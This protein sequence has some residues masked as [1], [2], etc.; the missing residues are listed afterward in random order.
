MLA[1]SELLCI[2]QIEL[3][4]ACSAEQYTRP[5]PQACPDEEPRRG[6]QMMEEKNHHGRVGRK[7]ARGAL[8]GSANMPQTRSPICGGATK[9]AQVLSG[10]RSG[11]R[12]QRPPMPPT[13]MRM[14]V[15][16]E[17]NPRAL[18]NLLQMNQ[19]ESVEA[20]Q[21]PEKRRSI[22]GSATKA[23]QDLS[24]AAAAASSCRCEQRMLLGRD[25]NQARSSLHLCP[26]VQTLKS[27]RG[28]GFESGLRQ[29]IRVNRRVLWQKDGVGTVATSIN[30]CGA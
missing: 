24:R 15:A 5:P 18:A 4:Q 14:W 26:D 1:E 29:R 19:H 6:A 10:A 27:V 9:A 2:V 21:M 25:Q 12:K 8:P 3:L 16:V 7:G 11:R 17:L 13:R 28:V 23:A 20:A 22:C 30:G